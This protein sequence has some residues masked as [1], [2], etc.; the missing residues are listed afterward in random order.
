MGQVAMSFPTSCSSAERG[1]ACPA[2][3]ITGEMMAFDEQL[4]QRV[5]ELFHESE[6]AFE[7]KKMMGGL[8]F[9][10][11]GKMCVGIEK[12]RL[13]ARIDPG[14]YEAA[15]GRRGCIPMDF[16]GRPMRGFVFV[17]PDGTTSRKDL[18]SWIALAL[19]FNPHALASR[20]PRN[21]RRKKTAK[22]STLIETAP[23]TK[24][25]RKK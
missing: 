4:A 1:P 23:S 5:R 6:V 22:P 10:V 21:A 20:R 8:C 19:E 25:K 16:T 15:L 12:D 11:N 13:M 18:K 2:Q 3:P 24:G 17:T 14:K 9:M 7:E